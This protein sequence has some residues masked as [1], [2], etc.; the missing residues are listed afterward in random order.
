VLPQ[1]QFRISEPSEVGAARRAALALAVSRGFDETQA[2]KVGLCV[3]EAATNIVKHAGTGKIVL[4]A[5][6]CGGVAGLEVIALDKG[7]GIPNLQASLRDGVST[8]GS[9]GTGLGAMTRLADH[10]ECYAP[11]GK[12]TVLRLEVWAMPVAT[13]TLE[14]GAICLPK[15]GET[16]SGDSW[17]VVTSKGRHGI[18]VA[19]GLGHGP[20]AAR[21]SR[22]ATRVL[23]ERPDV[24][25][26]E[27]IQSCHRALA[28][29]RG[30]AVAVARIS[31]DKVGFAGIG[32]IA[33]RIEAGDV[34]RQLVSHNGTLG[35]MLRRVQQFDFPLPIGA[36]LLFHSDG[37]ATHWH[38]ADYPGLAG[39]HP[40]IIAGVLY[41]DHER[42]R[43]DVTV[44]VVRNGGGAA[45]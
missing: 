19:D 38:L 14:L 9:P 15:T 44:L 7:P 45:G 13:S 42:G 12:G 35:H 41:R 25:P 30:A 20:D 37:L 5:L 8:A 4:R 34:R 28:P 32:N 31:T 18:L 39:R 16:V 27:I 3:T 21:A 2:G 10:F 23:E 1:I 6:E 29:T 22:A 26:A 36:L 40:G 17:T 11:A 24:E 43:D 33:C